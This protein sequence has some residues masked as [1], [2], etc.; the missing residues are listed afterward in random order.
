MNKLM[1]TEN[2]FNTDIMY[3]KF[4]QNNIEFYFFISMK[5]EISLEV[6]FSWEELYYN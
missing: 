1:K 4:L 3:I 5:W 6:S 2:I